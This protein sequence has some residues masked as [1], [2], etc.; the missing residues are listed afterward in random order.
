MRAGNFTIPI[1]ALLTHEKVSVITL[2]ISRLITVEV[3]RGGSF[4]FLLEYA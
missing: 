2:V 4:P 3:L 1:D